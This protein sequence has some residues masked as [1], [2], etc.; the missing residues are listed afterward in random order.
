MRV[1][2]KNVIL[3]L[4]YFFTR[5]TAEKWSL[6][7]K[8]TFWC[9]RPGDLA[10]LVRAAGTFGGLDEPLPELPPA[11][12]PGRRSA[13]ASPVLH[14]GLACS[15]QRHAGSAPSSAIEGGAFGKAPARTRRARPP[16]FVKLFKFL[17]LL[18]KKTTKCS[19]IWI[20]MLK[21]I[22]ICRF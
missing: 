19:I 2:I 10:D 11:E 17:I 22:K 12:A 13:A 20:Y 21:E 16:A 4:L 7:C 14:G 18:F 6:E 8:Y 15:A 9:E 3:H 1:I 5:Q